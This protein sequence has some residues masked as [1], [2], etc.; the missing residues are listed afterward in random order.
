[1]LDIVQNSKWIFSKGLSALVIVGQNKEE[2]YDPQMEAIIMLIPKLT[3]WILFE[4]DCFNW[5]KRAE[6]YNKTRIGK[7]ILMG[8][9][10]MLMQ[11]K[12]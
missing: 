6:K 12:H 3:W 8:N 5:K 1:M 4:G 2:C 10:G 7:K 9:Y 11:G